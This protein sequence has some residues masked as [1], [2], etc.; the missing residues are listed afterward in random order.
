MRPAPSTRALMSDMG[1]KQT[2]NDCPLMSAKC[3]EWTHALQQAAPSFDDPVG[4]AEQHYH[5]TRWN[6]S[7]AKTP[8]NR[9]LLS[10]RWRGPFACGRRV[11]G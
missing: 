6:S 8:S 2:S 1:Q 7:P 9:D 11:R 5:S 4:A 3:H 10:P